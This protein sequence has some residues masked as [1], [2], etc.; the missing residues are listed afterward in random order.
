[1]KVRGDVALE[2]NL[3]PVSSDDFLQK[4]ESMLVSQHRKTLNLKNCHV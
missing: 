2:N 1:M 3:S 4:G